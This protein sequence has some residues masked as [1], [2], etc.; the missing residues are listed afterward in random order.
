MWCFG[1]NRYGQVNGAV[2]DSPSG[3]V[4]VDKIDGATRIGTSGYDTWATV[5]TGTWTWGNN[6]WGQADPSQSVVNVAPTL[7][8][9]DS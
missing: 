2:S 5:D 8:P 1:S 9:A 7:I 4:Q 6:S 3:L